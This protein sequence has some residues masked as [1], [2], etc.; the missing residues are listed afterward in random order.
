MSSRK[1]GRDNTA[2]V[3]VDSTLAAL[4]AA[5]TVSEFTL[6]HR[7]LHDPAAP[8]RLSASA[9]RFGE[10]AVATSRWKKRKVVLPGHGEVSIVNDGPNKRTQYAGRAR[11]GGC[12]SWW[13]PM[14]GEP[15][16]NFIRAY[17]STLESLTP[18]GQ[19]T[20]SKRGRFPPIKG[21]PVAPIEDAA[22]TYNDPA[23]MATPS[24]NDPC[25]VP[26]SG[27]TV[28]KVEFAKRACRCIACGDQGTKGILAGELRLL[29]VN[30]RSIRFVHPACAT[31]QHLPSL[32]HLEDCV[33]G[34]GALSPEQRGVLR[35][36]D[37]LKVTP[38]PL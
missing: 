23:C 33:E 36:L 17:S 29:Y 37:V 11:A 1:R 21:G 9:T 22:S 6:I 8:L 12:L 27:V 2:A 24:P 10:I 35:A 34:F 28:C 18:F 31:A 38:P 32:R 20:V 19:V 5:L 16:W 25:N 3:A 14:A 26:A 7:F 4:P 30:G 15:Q 13:N